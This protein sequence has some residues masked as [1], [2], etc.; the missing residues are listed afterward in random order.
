[1]RKSKTEQKWLRVNATMT[2]RGWEEKW[3]RNL[4]AATIYF[5]DY[6]NYHG[7]GV[8]LNEDER[9][10]IQLFSH[11]FC[12][13]TQELWRNHMGIRKQFEASSESS[14]IFKRGLNQ[15]ASKK[16]QYSHCLSTHSNWGRKFPSQ[17]LKSRN[18][19]MK[20]LGKTWYQYEAFS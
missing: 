5:S 20:A 11:C 2:N 16:N 12:F 10:Y 9:E 6:R 4:T 19:W 17:Y 18:K 8:R 14:K 13:K 1:M 15:W 7:V 3:F